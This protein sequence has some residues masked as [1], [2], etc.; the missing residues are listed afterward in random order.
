MKKCWLFAIATLLVPGLGARDLVRIPAHTSTVS[1]ERTG[2]PVTIRI[3]EFLISPTEIT[4]AEYR[5]VMGSDPSV[6]SGGNLPVENVSWWDAIRY[7]NARSVREGLE[8]VYELPSGRCNRRRNGYRLP[9]EAEWL[10]AS[11]DDAKSEPARNAVLGVRDTK[12]LPALMEIVKRGPSPVASREPNQWGLYDMA[13]NVW[14]WCED[15]FDSVISYS[16]AHN[17]EGPSR[18]IARVVRGGSF[19]SSISGWTKGYRTSMEPE[20]RSRY[21]GFRVCRTATGAASRPPLEPEAKWLQAYN[22]RPAGLANGASALSPLLRAGKDAT[23]SLAQWREQAEALRTKW[24][25][26][27]GTCPAQ[28]PRP[29]FRPI[30][31]V[32][33]PGYTGTL[34]SLQMEP[35]SSED[36]FVMVPNRP[37]HLPRPVVIV[38]FYDVDASAGKNMGG[39]RFTPPGVRSFALDAV[40]QGWIAIAVRWF[41]ES[42]GESYTE[43]VANLALRHPGCSGLGKWV[44]DSHQVINYLVNR[45][46]VD[47][48]RIA[49]MGHSLG[50]K[51][52]LYA[53]AFDERIRVTVASEPGIGFNQSN[54]D[55]F[56]YFGKD[57]LKAA[58]GTDQHELLALI[59]PRA[60][61]LIGGDHYDG[62]NS[63]SYIDAAREVYRVYGAS[64]RIGYLNHH[65]GHSPTPEAVWRSMTWIQR[66]LDSY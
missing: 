43:A 19:A 56:W 4:G 24:G 13:G 1:D 17:P 27:L 14:E 35:D 39:R 20:R 51:M 34:G 53:A 62:N 22:N 31:V 6:Y 60:F 5:A 58:S 46:D 42:Y 30:E 45:P 28:I 32:H 57:F 18:G 26:L 50:G 9:T 48:A 16:L 44:A 11:G 65:T 64:Q 59:A 36:V 66:F 61:L 55:D 23:V 40:Q 41:G 33:E 63:W 21:T 15:W 52:A 25:G 47:P 37:S 38:P 8:P 7:C 2:I 49:I 12:D 3:D 10:L 54:Y 29:A